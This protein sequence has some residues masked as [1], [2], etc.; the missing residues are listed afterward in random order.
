MNAH[1]STVQY[2]TVA[3]VFA[4]CG[5]G[6]STVQYR[7][8]QYST[9]VQSVGGRTMDNVTTREIV[10]SRY[11]PVAILFQNISSKKGPAETASK[12]N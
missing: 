10:N 1:Y 4:E 5:R 3:P 6:D 12:N 8:V 2:S 9:V 11:K 7:T